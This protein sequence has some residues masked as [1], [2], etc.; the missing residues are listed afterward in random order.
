MQTP[1]KNGPPRTSGTLG[2]MHSD[3]EGG[4][5]RSNFMICAVGG[6]SGSDIG[7][8]SFKNQ[9]A[10]GVQQDCR[11]RNCNEFDGGTE[12]DAEERNRGREPWPV[13]GNLIS[14]SAGLTFSIAQTLSGKIE[15]R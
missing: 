9:K 11:I 15:I 7:N 10:L 4:K 3:F 12:E 13:R 5:P 14:S 6:Y 1:V 8:S 2:R